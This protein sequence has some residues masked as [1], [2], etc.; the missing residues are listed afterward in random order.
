MRLTS[1]P[2]PHGLCIST[3]DSDPHLVS[4]GIRNLDPDQQKKSK[5]APK[6]DTL[7]IFIFLKLDVLPLAGGLEASL[8]Y[9]KKDSD[10]P[11]PSRDVTYQT[12]PGG[13]QFIYSPPGRVW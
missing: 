9:K 3:T 2:L 11:V 10:F 13:E 4:I 1:A 6:K 8:H 5:L 12:L 7:R